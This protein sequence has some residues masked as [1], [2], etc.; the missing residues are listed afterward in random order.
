[1]HGD[2]A[3]NGQAFRITVGPFVVSVALEEGQREAGI[4]IK[5]A[6]I[7]GE[8]FVEGCVDL[9]ESL[10]HTHRRVVGVE[11][12]LGLTE[13]RHPRADGG[14]SHINRGDVGVLQFF[15]GQG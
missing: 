14:L 15:D 7:L 2:V 8:V 9:D 6:F 12:R 10:P 13:D 1:M 4:S 5:G 3:S 11:H